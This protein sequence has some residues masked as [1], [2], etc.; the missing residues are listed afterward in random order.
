MI[1]GYIRLSDVLHQMEQLDAENNPV[2]FDVKFVTHDKKRDIG[3][4]IIS[5]D[6]ARKCVGKRN[7]KVV[8]DVRAKKDDK[9]VKD[10]H[11][12][13]N[14]TRNIVL[15]NGQIRKLHIRLIIEFNGKKVCY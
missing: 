4:E 13:L 7:G 12:F 1:S 10:P 14:A 6:G 11:H 3:G 9:P 15:K 8:F 2:A 5:V